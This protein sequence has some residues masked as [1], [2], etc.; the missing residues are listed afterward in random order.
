[1]CGQYPREF[2][3]DLRKVVSNLNVNIQCTPKQPKEVHKLKFWSVIKEA[4]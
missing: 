1:M 3:R 4:F 2:N